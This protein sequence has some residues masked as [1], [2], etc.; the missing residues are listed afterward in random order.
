MS[1][2]GHFGNPIIKKVHQQRVIN[3]YFK[4]E[5]EGCIVDKVS[6]HRLLRHQ[7]LVWAGA[8]LQ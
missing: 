4:Y 1:I 2:G 8:L 5:V 7:S 6:A 3:G